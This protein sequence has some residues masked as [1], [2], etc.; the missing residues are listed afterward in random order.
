MTFLPYLCVTFYYGTDT[1]ITTCRLMRCCRHGSVSAVEV[2]MDLV[3]ATVLAALASGA[4]GEMGRQAWAALTSLVRSRRRATDSGD[5]S[6]LSTGEQ[7]LDELEAAPA[8]SEAAA[9]LAAVLRRRA[10]ADEEFAA[11]L[12]KLLA[13]VTPDFSQVNNVISG[14]VSGTAIQGR[15]FHGPITFT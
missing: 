10:E 8:D 3:S 6:A 2:E 9:R 11:D 7:E 12:T 14:T 13:P 4:G 15:D 5:L 1:D